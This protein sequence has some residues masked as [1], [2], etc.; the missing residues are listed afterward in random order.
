MRKTSLLLLGAIMIMLLCSCEINSKRSGDS[1]ISSE[2][3]SE[4]S[5]VNGPY[6][7]ILD[8]FGL[9]DN[10]ATQLYPEEFQKELGLYYQ[11]TWNDSDGA[12]SLSYFISRAD[13]ENSTIYYGILTNEDYSRSALYFV[14]I[15]NPDIQYFDD[16]LNAVDFHSLENIDVISGKVYDKPYGYIIMPDKSII[17]N[18]TLWSSTFLSQNQDANSNIYELCDINALAYVLGIDIQAAINGC[19]GIDDLYQ[20][21]SNLES[22]E[23]YGVRGYDSYLDSNGFGIIMTRYSELE[24]ALRNPENSDLSEVAYLSEMGGSDPTSDPDSPYYEPP[25]DAVTNTGGNFNSVS[26]NKRNCPEVVQTYLDNG[27]E[28]YK[29]NQGLASGFYYAEYD[30]THQFKTYYLIIQANSSANQ[31]PQPVL[32]SK[33]G[34][35]EY[36]MQNCSFDN[37]W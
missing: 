2:E 22:A 32:Y 28:V 3:S 6:N 13:Y 19:T 30:S 25:I 24:S 20:I 17:V 8:T 1:N 7:S 9:R 15:E 23:Y 14:S 29:I 12:F 10:E 36:N 27:Y 33:Y 4:I 5:A 11:Y 26:T 35:P 34:S 16:M 18:G 31:H 21:A 37:F